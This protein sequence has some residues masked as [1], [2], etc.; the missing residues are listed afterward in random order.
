LDLQAELLELLGDKTAARRLAQQ[1][2]IPVVPG[3]EQPVATQAGGEDRPR[4]RISRSSSKRPSAAADA[5]CA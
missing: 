2:G 5:A 4:D 3:T 1:A